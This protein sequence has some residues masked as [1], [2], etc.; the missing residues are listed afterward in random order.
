MARASAPPWCTHSE[1]PRRC[2]EGCN[3]SFTERQTSPREVL[4]Q[5]LAH[6]NGPNF[7][8]INL[9]LV[10]HDAVFWDVGGGFL[11]F[12]QRSDPLVIIE[13]FRGWV[14]FLLEELRRNRQSSGK[15]PVV[16]LIVRMSSPRNKRLLCVRLLRRRHMRPNV[17]AFHLWPRSTRGRQFAVR[18]R[19]NTCFAATLLSHGASRCF[20]PSPRNT[21]RLGTL[22]TGG[23]CSTAQAPRNQ[24]CSPVLSD[25]LLSPQLRHR[26]VFS[27]LWS[28]V[29]GL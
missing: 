4:P 5:E 29:L 15:C 27:W 20:V 24:G 7:F 6:L 22:S 16:H 1:L 18:E 9:F 3:F 21:R 17:P 14:L 13:L 8:W 19:R 10:I 23:M 11:R 26:R 2:R 25:T 28:S 12:R